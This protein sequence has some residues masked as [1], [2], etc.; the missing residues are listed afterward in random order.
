MLASTVQFSTND[1]PTTSRR[2]PAPPPWPMCPSRH[3]WLKQQPP[4]P[5]D[6]DT[7]GPR[8]R[9]TPGTTGPPAPPGWLFPQDPTGC[10]PPDPAAPT[11]GFPHPRKRGDAYSHPPAVARTDSPVSPPTSTPPPH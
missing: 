7:T 2:T 1:Q 11:D 3:A 8:H 9:R 4:T 10:S 5:P 6:P